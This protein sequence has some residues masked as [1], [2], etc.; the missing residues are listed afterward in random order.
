MTAKRF[1]GA[2][3]RDCL[4]RA[5]EVLG[6]D[7]VVISN[8]AV[9]NGVEIVAMSPES[10]DA[11]SQNVRPA[12]AVTPSPAP[13]PP[14]RSMPQADEDYT[15]SLASARIRASRQNSEPP[16][17]QPWIT[18]GKSA[19]ASTP[20]VAPAERKAEPAHSCVPDARVHYSPGVP[21]A[22][23][24]ADPM[25]QCGDPKHHDA[26]TGRKIADRP[27]VE[28]PV[29]TAQLVD[30]MRLIK[31]L[32]ERQL[33]GFAWGEMARE[34][35]TRAQLL[36]E[37]L[38]AGFSGG[39]TR[40]LIQEMAADLTQDEGR[41][42]LTA[43][44]N[45][46]LRTLSSDADFIDRGGVY[47]LVGPTGVGKTTTTAKLAARCVVRYGAERLALLTTDGYRIGAHEQLR[48]YGR[49]LGV[50]VFVVRDGEDLRRTLA[51][52]RDKH[53]VLI[54]T[55]GMSQR[56]RMVAE[57]AAMLTRSGEVNRLL[58][59]N[60]GSRGDTL[61]DVVRAY[62]GEDLAGC[63]LTKVDE[64]TALAPALDCI[65]RHGLTLSYVGNGQ[66][67]PED[68]HLPNRQYLLHRAFKLPSGE[69]AHSLRN[70]EIALSFPPSQ[71]AKLGVRI[72]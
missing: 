5:K 12:A 52:L 19:A 65:V 40:R 68:L 35:P 42:W 11:I 46:R 26:P 34:A 43:A 23:T 15:V 54:D 58:L 32:L 27:V 44:V 10:L 51:D 50:P 45:R 33:A 71:D 60:A 31:N 9:P 3:A 57:Q 18:Y 21:V 53:M 64:A 72:A 16:V 69:T 61:D 7:A 63:I 22:A 62:G 8:K 49:I 28:S 37:M 17:V 24:H 56:D 30:E 20:T 6:P 2:T 48:I 25:P 66:R 39:L 13:L 36:G 38:A 4:R 47:A 59:L 14:S 41:K 1:V 55:V 70:E 67:V 29:Q